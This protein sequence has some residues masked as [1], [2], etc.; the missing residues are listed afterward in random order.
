MTREENVDLKHTTP[1]SEPRRDPIDEPGVNTAIACPKSSTRQILG[2]TISRA[3]TAHVVPKICPRRKFGT[4]PL[5]TRNDFA[6]LR[7]QTK[8]A[9][10]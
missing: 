2:G 6:V 10:A 4:Y 3:R 9:G 7:T 1:M 5:S 8:V